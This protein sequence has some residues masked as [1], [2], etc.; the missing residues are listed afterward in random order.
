MPSIL[1]NAPSTFQSLV[2]D[3]FGNM[4]LV[5]VDLDDVVIPSETLEPSIYDLCLVSRRVGK[6]GRQMKVRKCVCAQKHVDLLR[7]VI[8]DDVI[9]V[10]SG[11]VTNVTGY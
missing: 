7:H 2:D 6:N 3:L 9:S 11:K 8:N 4:P 5:K 1:M 10:D